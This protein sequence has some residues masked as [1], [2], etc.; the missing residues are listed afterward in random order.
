[1]RKIFAAKGRQTDNPL[2]VHIADKND[3]FKLAKIYLNG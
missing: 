1:V 3:I 2:I